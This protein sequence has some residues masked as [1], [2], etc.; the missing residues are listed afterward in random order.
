MKPNMGKADKMIRLGI[1]AIIIGLYFMNVITGTVAI[2][3]GIFAAI[4]IATSFINFCP[5]YTVLNI[6]TNKKS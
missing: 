3:L 1:A 2:V 6:R 4:F 5:L